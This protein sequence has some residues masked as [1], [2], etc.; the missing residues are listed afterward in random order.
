MTLGDGDGNGDND[1]VIEAVLPHQIRVVHG[2]HG[3]YLERHALLLGAGVGIGEYGPEEGHQ[4]DVVP[5][6]PRGRLKCVR[7][8]VPVHTQGL[9]SDRRLAPAARAVGA[10]RAKSPLPVDL[11]GHRHSRH[12]L[13]EVVSLMRLRRGPRH[14]KQLAQEAQ[15][16]P[17]AGMSR[18]QRVVLRRQVLPPR[19]AWR[20]GTE[21]RRGLGQRR[22][23]LAQRGPPALLYPPHGSHLRP[24]RA[25]HPHPVSPPRAFL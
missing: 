8:P 11:Q 5:A 23:P 9:R 14:A 13:D 6:A 2:D 19:R 24:E 1:V 20:R 16:A 7:R 18:G 15:A 21:K 4:V 25:H 17:A 22:R 3:G 12:G 10:A